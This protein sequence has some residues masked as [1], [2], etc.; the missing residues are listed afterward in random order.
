MEVELQSMIAIKNRTLS[1]RLKEDN[2]KLLREMVTSISSTKVILSKDSRFKGLFDEIAASETLLTTEQILNQE[3]CDCQKT[4]LHNAIQFCIQTLEGCVNDQNDQLTKFLSFTENTKG[5][6]TLTEKVKK[7]L[8]DNAAFPNSPSHLKIK[9]LLQTD[10]AYSE[11][12]T[13]IQQQLPLA[14]N[15]IKILLIIERKANDLINRNQS[16][17][18]TTPA[19]PLDN[20]PQCLSSPEWT[21]SLK[22]THPDLAILANYYQEIQSHFKS[23]L[24]QPPSEIREKLSADFNQQFNEDIQTVY[25]DSKLK[26]MPYKLDNFIDKILMAIRNLFSSTS[27][28][29]RYGLFSD[30][31]VISDI[32]EG[33]NPSSPQSKT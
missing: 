4:K 13:A 10:N 23:Y 31:S 20:I 18:P 32:Q 9:S 26:K 19:M 11:T 14:Q 1:D 12:I 5:L 15:F 8:S 17:I 21:K 7:T 22:A 27:S 2:I 25:N 33:F 16:N 30:T 3:T 24:T 6:T 28:I 29:S